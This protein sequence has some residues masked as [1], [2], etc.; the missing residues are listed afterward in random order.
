MTR[1]ISRS[2]SNSFPVF[3]CIG[4][5]CCR[6]F[7][8]AKQFGFARHITH[9]CRA[10]EQRVGTCALE[11]VSGFIPECSRSSTAR[12]VSLEILNIITPARALGTPFVLSATCR[13]SR[14]AGSILF[15]MT[16]II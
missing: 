8:D 6:E 12:R 9:A 15:A 16:E 10:S 4:S 13:I 2:V 14:C 5:I 11:Y 7:T 3:R 1:D